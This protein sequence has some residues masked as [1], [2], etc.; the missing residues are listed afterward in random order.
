[1]TLPA[2]A[3]LR[4]ARNPDYTVRMT[5]DFL[6]DG[7]AHAAVT[8]LLAHGAGGAIDWEGVRIAAA[9]SQAG[10]RVARFE[11]AY[12]AARRAGARKPPPKA[13]R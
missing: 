9:L 8:V 2:F 13:E 5:L 6:F 11:F 7:D 4:S 3:M 1:M 10:L 12:M